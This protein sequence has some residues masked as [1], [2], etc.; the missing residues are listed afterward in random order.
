M[1]RAA[2]PLDPTLF[3]FDQRAKLIDSRLE[4]RSLASA[5]PLLQT[6]ESYAYQVLQGKSRER[7]GGGGAEIVGAVHA[8]PRM[9]WDGCPDDRTDDL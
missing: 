3:A 2:G 9:A 7:E 6:P 1:T 4:R 5:L 8:V